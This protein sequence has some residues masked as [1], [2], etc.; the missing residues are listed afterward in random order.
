MTVEEANKIIAE[1][2]GTAY[3]P[4]E[5]RYKISLGN[6]HESMQMIFYTEDLNSLIPIWEKIEYC[7]FTGD[8]IIEGYQFRLYITDEHKGVG[9][10]I[11]EAAA[12]ATANAILKLKN[13]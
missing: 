7:T 2:A 4:P 5:D 9:K 6:Y 13:K 12:I 10:T 1:F 8:W 3:I 11:Q